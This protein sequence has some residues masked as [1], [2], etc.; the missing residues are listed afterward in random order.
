MVH[1]LDGVGLCRDAVRKFA[2]ISETVASR[3]DY[4][5]AD[6][7]VDA[8]HHPT[9]LDGLRTG[10]YD[11]LFTCSRLDKSKRID[12][13]INAMRQANTRMQLKIAG[14]G[15]EEARLRDLAGNDPRIEFLGFVRDPDLVDLY[16]GRAPSCLCRRT[17]ITA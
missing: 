2:A 7:A 9:S 3:R 15:P 12:L 14:T 4:F 13:I 11:Y 1:W 8:I 10:N 16:A 17:K 5:P 6:V